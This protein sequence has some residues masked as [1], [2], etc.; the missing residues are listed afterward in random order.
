MLYLY[1]IAES[2]LTLF[3]K[4]R[5]THIFLTEDKAGERNTHSVYLFTFIGVSTLENI[6][7]SKYFLNQHHLWK[8]I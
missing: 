5:F 1:N 6:S 8:S 3:F 4:T 7:H 2:K